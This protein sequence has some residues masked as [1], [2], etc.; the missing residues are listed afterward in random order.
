MAIF[1]TRK[2]I[3]GI[4]IA[5]FQS[6]VIKSFYKNNKLLIMNT[7]LI[8][9]FWVLICAGLVFLMQ[10]G[11]TCM[12]SGLTRSKNSINVAIKNITDFGI[13]TILFWV[14]GFALMFGAT[15]GG[16]IGSTECFIS[17]DSG[18]QRISFFQFV[19]PAKRYET[20][21]VTGSKIKQKGEH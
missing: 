8:N 3:I 18:S 15:G 4:R 19:L 12:E 16:W 11:F 2:N 20:L 21:K 14:F 7:S 17:L 10:A 13:S 9:V 6:K 5:I 1:C